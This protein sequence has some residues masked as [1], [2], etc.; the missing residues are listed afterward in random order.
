[1]R[2]LILGILALVAAHAPAA[3]DLC[4][5][6]GDYEAN[7]ISYVCED[8]AFDWSVNT[9]TLT[10]G[11]GGAISV[12]AS[13]GHLPTLTG[14]YNCV[15][16]T[17]TAEAFLLDFCW[18]IY[19]LTGKFT[20]ATQWSGTFTADYQNYCD[21]CPTQS[22]PVQGVRG[23]VSVPGAPPARVTLR[24]EP[25]PVRSDVRVSLSLP[26]AERVRLEVLDVSGRRVALLAEADLTAGTHP[27]RWD[28]ATASGRRAPS[29]VYLVRAAAGAERHVT[30]IVAID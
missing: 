5:P 9:W 2:S 11:G 1:M 13:P 21:M 8:W 15:D 26:R 23:M 24:V 7:A 18:E 4:A 25:N 19:T 29:G 22:Y 30:R 27:V 16:S 10:D 28:R 14:T 17:F 6:A 20:S 12:T 3:A